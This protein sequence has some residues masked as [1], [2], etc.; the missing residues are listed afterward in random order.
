VLSKGSFISSLMPYTCEG[1]QLP[2]V[3]I[4]IG[5]DVLTTEQ[6]AELSRE[7]TDV[8]VSE[9]GQPQHYTWVIVHEVPEENW[10]VDRLTVPELK[11]KLRERE[12]SV[13]WR[14]QEK[15][16]RYF[17]SGPS[18]FPVGKPLNG[19]KSVLVTLKERL[20]ITL[21]PITRMGVGERTEDWEADFSTL[22]FQRLHMPSWRLRLR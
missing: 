17:Y 18:G 1:N 13:T 21:G 14:V 6:I 11:A 4:W 9:A 3:M 7:I 15:I 19:S 12:K 2:L 5:K 10:M 8:I 20:G 22:S 16:A